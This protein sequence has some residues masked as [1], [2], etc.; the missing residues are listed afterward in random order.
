MPLFNIVLNKDNDSGSG[1]PTDSCCP[2]TFGSIM[3]QEDLFRET[4]AGSE[5]R[6]TN[7][8]Q[9]RI[10][11]ATSVDATSR[12]YYGIDPAL[13]QDTGIVASGNR[14]HE[15]FIPNLN[16]DTLYRFKVEST[17]TV[18]NAG[19]ETLTSET[20]WFMIGGE[21]NVVTGQFDFTITTGL[22]TPITNT[23]SNNTMDATADFDSTEPI[24][25][26]P[27]DTNPTTSIITITST[28]SKTIDNTMIFTDTPTTSVV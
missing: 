24:T 8:L 26:D 14:Y 22:I 15:V 5:T 13:D 10:V 4:A 1:T 18:C 2:F 16:L 7:S 23:T 28:P 3:G 20:Y 17:S 21:L 27:L 11:W 6:V 9:A 25:R 19:G 12:V